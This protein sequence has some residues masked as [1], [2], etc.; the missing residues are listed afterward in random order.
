MRTESLVTYIKRLAPDWSRVDILEFINDIQTMVFGTRSELMRYID[1]TTG[2]NPVLTTEDGV[3]E[4]ILDTSVIGSDI[5]FIEHV[6]DPVKVVESI[7]RLLKPGGVFWIETPNI[8]SF[9]HDIYGPDWRGLEPPRHLV[10]FN[11]TTLINILH[12]IG[13]HD[14]VDAPYRP[15]CKNTFQQ[16]DAIR[17]GLD[18]YLPNRIRKFTA[19]KSASLR[20]VSGVTGLP[21]MRRGTWVLYGVTL[22]DAAILLGLGFAEKTPYDGLIGATAVM[23]ALCL[24][25]FSTEALFVHHQAQNRVAKPKT[26]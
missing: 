1:P 21:E 6:Y 18:P 14:V 2:H 17:D 9:G 7:Y 26:N 5:Q 10:L 25:L 15:L 24:A 16:S 23:G 11:R 8:D 20:R 13:F 12:Q 22:L 3:L 19:S 4:Y